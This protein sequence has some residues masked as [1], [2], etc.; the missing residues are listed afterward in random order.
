MTTP[1]ISTLN[2]YNN[3][4]LNVNPGDIYSLAFDNFNNIII[5]TNNFLLKLDKL[6][7]LT[8]ISGTG[9]GYNLTDTFIDIQPPPILF[10]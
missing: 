7:N 10:E 1:F 4:S 5:G 3:P 2:L 8:P 6:G 9:Y